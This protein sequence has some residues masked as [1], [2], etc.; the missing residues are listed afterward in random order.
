MAEQMR[1]GFCRECDKYTLVKRRGVNHILH[2]LLSITI[3]WIPVWIGLCLFNIGGWRCQVCGSDQIKDTGEMQSVRGW[4]VIALSALLIVPLVIWFA[5]G[6]QS[7][8]IMQ[9]LAPLLIW[10]PIVALPVLIVMAVMRRKR[11]AERLRSSTR[12]PTISPEPT[13]PPSQVFRPQQKA[14]PRSSDVPA[15]M[16][17][18]EE[19]IER[20]ETDTSGAD[21]FRRRMQQRDS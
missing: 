20:A 5:G 14:E 8:S 7:G 17:V 10:V 15:G 11:Q 3:F 12:E 9:T 18:S 2:L 6:T 1:Q 4:L 16:I 19:T 13:S 21:E